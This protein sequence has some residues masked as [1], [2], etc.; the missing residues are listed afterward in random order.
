MLAEFAEVLGSEAA[1]VVV[2]HFRK[3]GGAALNL[4]NIAQA[5]MS[6]WADSWVLQNHAEP[7]RP[8]E[9]HFRL[10]VQYGSRQ[11]GGRDYRVTWELGTFDDEAGEHVGDITYRAESGTTA[12]GNRETARVDNDTERA[13]TLI[14]KEPWRYTRGGLQKLLGGNK[15]R[16][17]K[18]ID[19]L[20]V[21][22]QVE[23]QKHPV[24]E[25]G[26][27]V[28]REVLGPVGDG[29]KV[30]MGNRPRRH[31]VSS[32][33]EALA[34]IKTAGNSATQPAPEPAPKSAQ[35]RERRSNGGGAGNSTRPGPGTEERVQRAKFEGQVP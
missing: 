27:M 4:D 16:L 11:W 2:D 17:T 35:T 30:R 13:L 24:P 32:E 34:S 26:R 28:K 23:L 14:R 21:L 25:A 29:L 19:E 31:G 10:G 1:L 7:P 18:A 15:Q 33:P 12:E 3:T 6:Q 9:G 20:L 8:D 22:G 5:G